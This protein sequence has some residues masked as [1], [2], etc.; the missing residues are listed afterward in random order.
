MQNGKSAPL[1]LTTD[2]DAAGL[3]W[4]HQMAAHSTATLIEPALSPPHE[5]PYVGLGLTTTTKTCYFYAYIIW[6]SHL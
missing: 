3:C 2:S 6:L 1:P 4:R 5:V